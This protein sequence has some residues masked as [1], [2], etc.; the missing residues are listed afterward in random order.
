MKP[1]IDVLHLDKNEIIWTDTI[2]FAWDTIVGKVSAGLRPVSGRTGEDAW[3]LYRV[4][5]TGQMLK[6]VD[7]ATGLYF[8]AKPQQWD[9]RATYT[10]A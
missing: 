4:T 10:Y 7:P 8:D 2:T 3:Y 1:V 6:P 5:S 9:Q